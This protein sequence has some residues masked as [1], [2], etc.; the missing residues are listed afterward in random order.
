M[1]YD[2]PE[3]LAKEWQADLQRYYRKWMG[4]NATVEPS[5]LYRHTDHFGLNF[6]HLADSLR[7]LQV[8]RWHIMKH[9]K[10]DVFRKIYRYRLSEDQQGHT[11][12]GRKFV[13]SLELESLE[14]KLS[15]QDIVGNAQTDFWLRPSQETS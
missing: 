7:S 3:S 4:L 14:G 2:F 10:D 9:A 13:P 1:I 8:T 6:K 12:R 5:I 11:G 15:T